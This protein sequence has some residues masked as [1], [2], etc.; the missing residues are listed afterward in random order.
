MVI[1]P[2]GS[3]LSSIGE[4]VVAAGGH[5][6]PDAAGEVA[7]RRL[8]EVVAGADGSTLVLVV[9]AGG[10]SALLVA[11]APGIDL[12]DKQEVTRRLLLAGADIEALNT[13]R[14]HCSRV[15]G[16]GLL[17]VAGRASGVWALLL[18]D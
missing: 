15:K 1:V 14:K 10:A 6:V 4:I 18:S 9:L 13:V 12:R 8:S 2:H 7:T 5:P 11:P 3:D 17:R 16:G